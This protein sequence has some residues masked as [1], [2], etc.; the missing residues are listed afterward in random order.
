MEL[1]GCLDVV[2]LAV[3]LVNEEEKRAGV[4][5]Y[6]AHFFKAFVISVSVYG[7]IS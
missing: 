3:G 5:T 4:G 7:F 1:D 2:L 6:V